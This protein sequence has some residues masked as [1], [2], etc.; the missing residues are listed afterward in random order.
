MVPA[1]IES[2]RK[3]GYRV[4]AADM[5]STAAGLYCADRGYVIPAGTTPD[6]L[7]AIRN[8]CKKSR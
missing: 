3:N 1:L 4:L 7:S 2:L 8:I 5:D 6:F